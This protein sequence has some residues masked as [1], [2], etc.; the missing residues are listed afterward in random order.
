VVVL[1]GV[2]VLGCTA[3]SP[4]PAAIR[5]NLVLVVIDTLRADHVGAYGYTRATTPRLDALA[6]RGVRFEGAHA[7]TSWTLPSVVSMLTGTY[8]AEHGV[9][10]VDSALNEKRPTIATLLRAAGYETAAFCANAAMLTEVQGVAQGFDRFE[11]VSPAGEDPFKGGPGADRVTDAALAWLAVRDGSWPYFLYVHY[12]DP[13]GPYHPPSTYA[14]RFGM[15]ADEPMLQNPGKQTM[16]L[17]GKVPAEP[18]LDVLR[19]LYDGEIAFTDAEVGR[20]V[21]RLASGGDDP[22]VV[23][24][25]DH[26]EEFGEHGGMQH[27]RT[28][29]EEVLHVPLLVAGAGV[30]R[31]VVVTT[32]VSLVSLAATFLD[33]AR[34]AT[35]TAFAGASLEPVLR[36]EP[37]PLAMLFADLG[38][39]AAQ[40]RLA[41]IDG[42]WKLVLDKGFVAS[43]YDL[44]ADPKET[45]SRH[46][47]ETSRLATMHKA[48]GEHNKTAF[49]ARATAPPVKR[50]IDAN[51]N[52]RLKA[53]GYVQ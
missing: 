32:P 3:D 23:V 34:V 51:R 49:K 50:A 17:L 21:D 12:F 39:P 14:Q 10:L 48:A 7:A 16:A 41:A 6:A 45:V 8:P 24:T 47:T 29:F 28:L 30:A 42:S 1:A 31:G 13:H 20:L 40:H 36:G 53:L 35:T 44:A 26:G 27:G 11:N 43:L 4:R 33:F 9:D 5:P 37:A 52:D 46:T 38:T 18:E 15:A 22:L 25:A 19:T 2:L